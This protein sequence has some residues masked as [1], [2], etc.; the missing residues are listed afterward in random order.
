MKDRILIYQDYT[1]HNFGLA[2]KLQE[3]H[4]C[5]LF[6][7][8]D[9]TDNMNKFFQ[10]QKIVKY[11][12]TWFLYDYIKKNHKPNLD[13]LS[14]FEKK[15]GIELWKLAN[16]DRIFFKYNMYYNFSE[17]EILSILEQ[18]CRLFENI[19]E[20]IK[21]DFV[22][23]PL[24]NSGRMEIFY[25]LCLKLGIKILMLNATRL[26]GKV[27]INEEAEKID[28]FEKEIHDKV[29]NRSLE[30]LRSILY[31]TH[32][33]DDASKFTSQFLKSKKMALKAGLDFF[34]FSKN[35]NFKTHYTYYGR[36]KIKIFFIT[37]I[38]SLRKRY[39]LYLINK[40]LSRTIDDEKFIFFPLITEPER[41]L[42]IAAPFHTN[43]IELV[44]HIVKS[45]PVGYKLYVKD[46]IGMDTRDWRS[47]SFYKE[48]M[49]LPNVKMIHH[50]VHP[51]NILP[52]CSMVITIGGTAGFE[53][54]FYEK[55]T[56]TFVDTLYSSLKSVEILNDTKE[57]PQLIQKQL[58]VK[59]DL[60]DLNNFIFVLEKNSFPFDW[61]G[62]D[63]LAH[64][65]LF[66]DGFL[67]DVEIS[68]KQMNELLHQYSK[69]LETLANEHIKKIIQHQK[70]KNC[71]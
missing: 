45:L 44:T 35:S 30:D 13:Y 27:F 59:F 26:G 41:G 61:S 63:N 65:I 15:Y 8:I 19:I 18:E 58:N 69:Q 28:Y 60:N 71:D 6:A 5:D 51:K 66:Y 52:K 23:F 53:A 1:M 4:N 39:R 29:K 31:K 24:T 57:L 70:Y 16:N 64:H 21:P 9:V 43:L 47:F 25:Q 40:N 55:P 46:H 32:S 42:N 37:I 22:I 20:T 11:E 56:I 38:W 36:R 17:T 10:K 3:Q 49:D 62:F 12:K 34:L 67:S 54:A 2:K 33:F 48:I 50:A 68:E 7:F 14:K